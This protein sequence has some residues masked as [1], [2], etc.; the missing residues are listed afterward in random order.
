MFAHV[1]EELPAS[2]Q[3]NKANVEG[4]GTDIKR[5]KSAIGVLGA[6]WGKY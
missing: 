3:S 5:E 6:G 1:S 4:N 2:R